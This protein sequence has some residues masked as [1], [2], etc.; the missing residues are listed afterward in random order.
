MF[1]IIA[2]KISSDALKIERK[3]DLSNCIII[4]RPAPYSVIITNNN[5]RIA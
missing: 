1:Y 5:N 2:Y 3:Q 4:T